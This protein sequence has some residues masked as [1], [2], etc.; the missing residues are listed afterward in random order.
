MPIPRVLTPRRAFAAALGLATLVTLAAAPANEDGPVRLGSNENAFGFTPKAEAALIKAIK[1]GNYYNRDE[2][3]EMVKLCAAREGVPENFILPTAGSGP[4][5]LMTAAAFGKPGAN[6][7]NCAP[8]YP[9]LTGAFTGFGG[10][11]K[12]VYV[13]EKGGA[14]FKAMLRAIDDKTAIAYVCNP[15]NPTGVQADPA[16]LRNFIMAVPERVL[17]FVD[18]AYLELSDAGYKNSTVTPLVKLKKNLIVSHTFSKAFGLAGFRAGYGVAQPELLAKLKPYYQGAP[19]FLAA[20]AAQEALKDTK[21]MEE[22]RQKYRDV[23]VMVCKEFDKMGLKYFAPQG[24]FIL[25][26]AGMDSG[27]VQKKMRA[28][29]IL[30]TRPFGLAP[31]QTGYEDWVRVSIGT[32]EEMYLFLGALSKTLGKT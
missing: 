27:E 9:Q 10:E 23:R 8:G 14:D 2:V 26:K 16:E 5:L 25:F 18:E 12:Y 24:A 4:V 13:N 11:I 6:V 19:S 32:Q 3:D 1:T 15:N 31:G 29:N 21:F 20:V 28:Q 17:V 22:N 30:V 7:V